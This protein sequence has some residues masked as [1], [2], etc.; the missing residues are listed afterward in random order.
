[1]VVF[2]NEQV[3]SMAEE[4]GGEVVRTNFEDAECGPNPIHPS[5]NECSSVEDDDKSNDDG[6]E[7]FYADPAAPAR[8]RALGLDAKR[9]E[10]VIDPTPPATAH[11]QDSKCAADNHCGMKTA[12]LTIGGH[13]CLNY[14][15]KTHGCLCGSLWA[16]KGDGC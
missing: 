16:E 3:G 9:V 12:P 10:F 4:I 2:T 11:V 13:V 8:G 14:H 7:E 5:D 6:I 15:K 1:M